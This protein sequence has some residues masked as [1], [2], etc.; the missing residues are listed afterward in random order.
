MFRLLC[1]SRTSGNLAPLE[2]DQDSNDSETTQTTP[3]VEQEQVQQEQEQVPKQTERVTVPKHKR[4]RKEDPLETLLLKS[5][6][7]RQQG[8]VDEDRLFLL[9]LLSGL[10]RLEPRRK[11]ETKLKLQQVLYDAE[12][13][14]TDN[15]PTTSYTNL[16]GFNYE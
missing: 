12:Y 2:E 5:L 10:K 8:D 9:S 1:H 7:D 3:E 13:P 14:P 4:G 6:E 11:M 15:L 16:V